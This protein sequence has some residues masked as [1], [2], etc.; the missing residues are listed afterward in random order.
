[1]KAKMQAFSA[2]M[3][4]IGGGALAAGVAGLAPIVV[5]VKRF[6][7]T[8][9]QMNKIAART[10]TT[11]E[12]ISTL[13]FAATESGADVGALEKGFIGMS[14][15]IRN[16]ERGLSTA[17][18]AL[19]TVGI[20]LEDLEGKSPDEQMK[21]LAD[22]L[23]GLDEGKRAAVAMEL[24][25]KS[26]QKLIPM[27][28]AGSAGIEKMQ[29][30]AR[31]LNLEI[32]TEDANSAAEL[33]DRMFELVEVLKATAF[34]IGA[35][36]APSLITLVTWLSQGLSGLINWVKENRQLVTIFAGVA[37]GLVVFGLG[38]MAVGSMVAIASLAVS[39]FI[40]LIGLAGS[41]L[42]V[43]LSPIGLIAVALVAGVAAWAYYSESG[44]AAV[45]WLMASL[46][47]LWD[48]TSSVFGGVYDAIAAG[49]W[50]LAGEIM[51]TA[52]QIA[53]RT[54][55]GWLMGIW[56]DFKFGMFSAFDSLAT[57]I[58]G[59][60]MT[61]VSAIAKGVLWLV[62]KIN[63]VSE[64][65]TGAKAIALDTDTVRAALDAT[66][67]VAAKKRNKDRL[68]REMDRLKL[69]DE[70][71]KQYATDDLQRQLEQSL[72]TASQKR[73]E[74]ELAKSENE[75][76]QVEKTALSSGGV[77]LNASDK[78]RTTSS[79]GT[80]SLNAAQ[81]F[82]ATRVSRELENL[83]ANKRAADAVE[84]IQE[85]VEDSEGQVIT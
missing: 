4:R 36:V 43:V 60:W 2:G 9:D 58:E 11:A 10:N 59:M 35:A 57:G 19:D 28:N 65:L 79:E 37:V 3:S 83:N 41:I 72:Q 32:S 33:T 71:K 85:E 26:G 64:T 63:S 22:G 69:I 16:A 27:L 80:F 77:G 70:A 75:P 40:G 8:G 12:A 39:A 15:T 52:L 34:Q 31:D 45:N 51:W 50:G 25:G 62:D 73:A 1:M 30:Q 76:N 48:W 49:E 6:M 44:N 46:G 24:F 78:K 82:S 68:K 47:S 61:T 17:K 21:I 7:K 38:F 5:G 67:D 84:A 55:V 20:S 23:V 54:G 81:A 42:G 66:S 56:T 18:D 14:K 13:G 53:W 29:Q 74:A